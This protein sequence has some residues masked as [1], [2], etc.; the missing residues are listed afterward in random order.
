MI[1][2]I[3]SAF[4]WFYTGTLIAFWYETGRFTSIVST[5]MFSVYVA[6]Y[7]FVCCEHYQGHHT[8]GIPLPDI[9]LPPAAIFFGL[10]LASWMNLDINPNR[11]R[12][13]PPLVHAAK[14]TK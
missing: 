14:Y 4:G 10:G 13:V 12:H 5:I 1:L 6:A 9:S 2:A 11:K 7:A 3:S 8:F